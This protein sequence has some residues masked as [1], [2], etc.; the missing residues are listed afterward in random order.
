MSGNN[1]RHGRKPYLS[2][3]VCRGMGILI[4]P[5]DEASGRREITEHK[6]CAGSGILVLRGLR[7]GRPL[8]TMPRLGWA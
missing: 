4:G 7:E 5:M 8:Y 2:C 3:A 1:G 6:P